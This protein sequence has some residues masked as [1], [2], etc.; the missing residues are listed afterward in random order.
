MLVI[1]VIDIRNGKSVRVV[2]GLEDKMIYYSESPLTMAQLFRKENAKCLH[3]T[4]LD[5]AYSG[6]MQN[7]L[8]IKEITQIIGIPVQL[9]G[10][11]RNMEI[12]RQVLNELGVYRIVIGTS[13]IDNISFVQQ[14]LEEFSP[15][16]I[17]IGIDV[18]NGY[19]VKDGWLNQTDIRGTDFALAMKALGVERI[20]YQD[21]SKVGS[22][23]GPDLDG[24]KQMA[25]LTGLK[26]TAA[27]G[28]GG[29]HDLRKVQN[30]EKSGVDSVMICRALYENKFPCQAIW[31][32]IEQMDVSLDLPEIPKTF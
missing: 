21:V 14:L 27:G 23:S 11:I 9:G 10:G 7:Y 18:R 28:I 5:G 6:D 31:R 2:E 29:Y 19:I 17:I 24:L 20:I 16:K 15:R 12:A 25:V 22:L 32:E 26:I 30:L 8:L 1:P 4:D 3:I 13:A